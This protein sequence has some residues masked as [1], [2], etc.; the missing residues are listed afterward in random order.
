MNTF[1]SIPQQSDK[2]S[3]PNVFNQFLDL[4]RSDDGPE[5]EIS[6]I[7]GLLNA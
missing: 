1:N 4:L 7:E 3:E 6:K 2:L 5:I